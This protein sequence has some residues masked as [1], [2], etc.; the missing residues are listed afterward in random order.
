MQFNEDNLEGDNCI[1]NDNNDNN[2]NNN[3]KEKKKKMM[4]KYFIN[5]M[6]SEN[7]L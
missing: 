6:K 4:M 3:K 5:I 2:E 7:N 1:N